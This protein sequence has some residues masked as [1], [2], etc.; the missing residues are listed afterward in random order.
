MVET[1]RTFLLPGNTVQLEKLRAT[2]MGANNVQMFVM[3]LY[4]WNFW[5]NFT[6]W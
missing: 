2:A 3:K 1:I 5:L 4:L 6:F